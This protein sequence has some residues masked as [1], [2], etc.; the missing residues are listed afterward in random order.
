MEQRHSSAH[1]LL[2]DALRRQML[3]F[4]TLQLKDAALAEDATPAKSYCR[5]C[6]P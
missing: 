4:A 2:S 6:T 3:Q 1:P 5:R